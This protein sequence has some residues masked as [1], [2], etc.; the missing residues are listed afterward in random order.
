MFLFPTVRNEVAPDEQ[1]QRMLFLH[2]V[3][4]VISFAQF[5]HVSPLF[6]HTPSI[7][8][9]SSIEVG[10]KRQPWRS[11]FPISVPTAPKNPIRTQRPVPRETKYLV[12]HPDNPLFCCMTTQLPV[13]KT[14]ISAFLQLFF[15]I[16]DSFPSS[17]KRK[18]AAPQLICCDSG[19]QFAPLRPATIRQSQK[20]AFGPYFCFQTLRTA[21]GWSYRRKAPRMATRNNPV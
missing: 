16:A 11:K 9:A 10:E 18:G 12:L 7:K 4:F 15:A 19:P 2:N 5:A 21:P 17:A 20:I 1:V 13:V 8:G 6:N 14:K 3:N